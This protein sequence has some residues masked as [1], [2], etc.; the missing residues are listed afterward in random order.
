MDLI[1]QGILGAAV[2]QVGFQKT[3]GRRA[4]VWG[5][6]LGMLP[7]ADVF[8]RLSSNPF[9]EMIHHRGITHSLW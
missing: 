5:A 7:D 3:L 2:S 8:I 9:A 6:I 4:L 1:T